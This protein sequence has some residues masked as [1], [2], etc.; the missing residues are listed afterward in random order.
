M[1]IRNDV[2]LQAF[3]RPS[4]TPPP[5][6][7]AHTYT[8]SFDHAKGVLNTQSRNVQLYVL[9]PYTNYGPISVRNW[10]AHFRRFRAHGRTEASEI[11]PR[12]PMAVLRAVQ[13]V[14]TSSFPSRPIWPASV[15][16]KSLSLAKLWHGYRYQYLRKWNV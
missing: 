10:Q 8:H 6:S 15:S 9:V 11:N 5:S 2:G 3:I 7:H 13:S 4:P 1:W 16:P 12:K 14:P